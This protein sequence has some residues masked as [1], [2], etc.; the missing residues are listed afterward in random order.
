[1]INSIPSLATFLVEVQNKDGGWSYLQNRLSRVEP[2]AW[3]V[4]GLNAHAKELGTESRDRALQ[5][6][7]EAQSSDGSYLSVPEVG[8][9]VWTTAPALLALEGINR[10]T[11]RAAMKKAFLSL[12]QQKAKTVH[13]KDDPLSDLEAWG[14]NTSAFSWVEPTCLAILALK[15]FSKTETNEKAD[16]F[17]RR[18]SQG[19]S[20]ILS[21]RC[22]DG[23]WN[24]GNFG[25]SDY[26]LSSFP[27]PTALVLLT[28]QKSMDPAM[29]LETWKRLEE[30]QQNEASLL[31]LS[32]AII[33]GKVLDYDVSSFVE[34]LF[35]KMDSPFV[36]NGE[37]GLALYSL[38]ND[39][40][41]FKNSP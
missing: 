35:T 31:S 15:G 38:G 14:W 4:L 30:L 19:E 29:L 8:S 32:W 11:D 12:L 39:F 7:V 27:V 18:I 16:E 24:Y 22:K 20:V 13:K 1:M 23:G 33:A 5:W 26:A 17:H 21:R 37:R 10:A 2:T 36:N 34:K 6:L 28:L 3:I 9:S 25:N 41:L 40:S